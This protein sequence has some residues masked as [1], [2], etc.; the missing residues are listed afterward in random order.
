MKNRGY[1]YFLSIVA[2][3]G[4]FLFGFDTAV[5]SGAERSIQTNWNLSDWYHGVAVAIALYGTVI[6]ALFGG[7]PSD[8]YGRKKVLLWIGILYF[9]SALGS[10]MATDVY[11]FMIFRFLGGLGVGA[12]SVVAPM[13]ISEIAPA[14]N[15]GKLVAL[16]QFNIVFGILMA[17]FSNYLI[18][19]T[20]T[21]DAWRYM[22]GVEAIP[23]LI[24]TILVLRVPESPRWL[25]VKKGD[26]SSALAILMKTDPD[27]AEDI[28]ER[29]R[30]ENI[31]NED[32]LNFFALF[33]KEYFSITALAVAIAVFNQVSGINAI[34]Y[35]AP[36]IF[37]MAGIATESALLSTIGIGAVNLICT[38][39]GLLLID[40]MGRRFL[41]IV[42]SA[43]YIVSL[44]L[45]ALSFQ[46]EFFPP[47]WL[48]IFVFIFIG[49]HAIGQGSVIWVFISEIFPNKLRAK[50]QSLGSFTHWILA[51]LIAN[52]FPFLAGT[53]GPSLIFGFFGLMMVVQLFWVLFVMP[54]T[55]GK[56]LEDIEVIQKA[57]L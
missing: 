15:R 8:K 16:F 31:R 42:G 33:K 19:I 44:T 49:A 20:I 36:R 28:V 13:Y 29:A 9:V 30:P 47:G 10:A 35:F 5:I 12:S 17:Y 14:N 45:M 55:K 57:K 56:T 54:E 40:R 6:G 23:A 21:M 51:A 39:L 22:L 11:T 48:P 7:L 34:I 25:V 26:T 2:A 1:V 53:F 32:S 27:A 18:G 38:M 46:G 37:E 24:Y 41:M 52:V 4:G 50:G 43:G 3:L